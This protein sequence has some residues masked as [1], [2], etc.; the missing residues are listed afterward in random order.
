M[1]TEKRA[2]NFGTINGMEKA[3]RR[4]ARQWTAP[5]S[6]LVELAADLRDDEKRAESKRKPSTS[7]VPRRCENCRE[8]NQT[9]RCRFC[10]SS[11]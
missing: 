1:T 10:R 3:A 6:F 4:N 8:W 5:P 11:I 7:V 2:P 9:E